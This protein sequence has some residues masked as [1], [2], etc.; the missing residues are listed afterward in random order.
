MIQI[1]KSN[2]GMYREEK[3]KLIYSEIFKTAPSHSQ[4]QELLEKFSRFVE[5]NIVS[6]PLIQGIQEFLTKGYGMVWTFLLSL[7]QLRTRLN[8]LLITMR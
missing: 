6:C 7:L 1:H 4:V 3:I 8:G 2:R 5:T